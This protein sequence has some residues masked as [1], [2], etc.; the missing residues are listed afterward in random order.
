MKAAQQGTHA[1]YAEPPEFQRH[2]G[3]G[4]F[5]GS[6]AEED[7]LAIAGYLAMTR[8]QILR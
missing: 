8:L 6:S 4:R 5:V 2:P 7:D 1:A 3:A